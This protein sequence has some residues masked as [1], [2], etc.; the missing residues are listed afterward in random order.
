[1]CESRHSI[2]FKDFHCIAYHFKLLNSA[3]APPY[4]YKLCAKLCSIFDLN[5][6]SKI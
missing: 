6:Y 4:K 1:M 2:G 3:Y 5:S